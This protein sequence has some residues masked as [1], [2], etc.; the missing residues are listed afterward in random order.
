[1]GKDVKSYKPNMKKEIT[2]TFF[3]PY[4]IEDDQ[5]RVR[6]SVYYEVDIASE[7]WCGVDFYE[8]IY[9]SDIEIPEKDYPHTKLLSLNPLPVTALNN[10]K[11]EE[12]YKGKFEYFNPI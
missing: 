10:E 12:L 3:V 7:R 11:Y 2:L 6:S 5:E 4:E 8:T 9:L 1:M